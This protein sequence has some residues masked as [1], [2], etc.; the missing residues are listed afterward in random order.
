MYPA[1]FLTWYV[2]RFHFPTFIRGIVCPSR[3]AQLPEVLLAW[4]E[5]SFKTKLITCSATFMVSPWAMKAGEQKSITNIHR[6]TTQHIVFISVLNKK[7]NLIKLGECN[8]SLNLRVIEVMGNTT[9]RNLRRKT[10]EVL[11]M[12]N[13]LKLWNVKCNLQQGQLFV[14]LCFPGEKENSEIL[15]GKINCRWSTL[16]QIVTCRGTLVPKCRWR[17]AQ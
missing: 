14:S 6:K 11:N 5:P 16:I 1:N 12:T 13:W 4:D 9:A 2:T 15:K 7:L 17:Q 10:N 3:Y 8:G